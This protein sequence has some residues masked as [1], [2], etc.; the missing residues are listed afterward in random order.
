MKVDMLAVNSNKI[1]V[2]QYMRSNLL[3]PWNISWAL[4]T[5]VLPTNYKHWVINQ[6]TSLIMTKNDPNIAAYL[7]LIYILNKRSK[8]LQNLKIAQKSPSFSSIC[9]NIAAEIAP[10]LTPAWHGLLNRRCLWW[11]LVML[12]HV[13]KEQVWH[14]SYRNVHK[15][16]GSFL[17]FNS[18]QNHQMHSNIKC[19]FCKVC[20]RRKHQGY[21]M[22]VCIYVYILSKEV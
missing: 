11:N 17:S 10:L 21:N 16:I 5:S 13:A 19:S 22:Y 20:G 4:E 18:N 6:E 9:N 15:Y 1:T 8:H 2:I 12:T 7:N 14:F 3:S